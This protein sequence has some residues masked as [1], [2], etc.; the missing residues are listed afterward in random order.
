MPNIPRMGQ[1]W[2]PMGSALSLI[3]EAEG[4]D[5]AGALEAARGEIAGN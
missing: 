5:V 4:S 2:G 3:L 1:V